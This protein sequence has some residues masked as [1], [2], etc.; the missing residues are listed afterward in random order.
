MH[1][2]PPVETT[3]S[4]Q[5]RCVALAG[6]HQ[7]QLLH[8]TVSVCEARPYMHRT[9]R[10]VCIPVACLRNHGQQVFSSPMHWQKT[11]EWYNGRRWE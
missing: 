2:I 5:S 1:A 3:E 10:L 8:T 11:F 6:V 4:S 9:N 7:K